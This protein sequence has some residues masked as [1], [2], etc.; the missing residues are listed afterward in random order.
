MTVS[1]MILSKELRISLAHLKRKEHARNFEGARKLPK[2]SNGF[3]S[4]S[5]PF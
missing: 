1:R 3:A 2:R 5:S 4:K